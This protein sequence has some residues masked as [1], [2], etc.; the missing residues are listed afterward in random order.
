MSQLLSLGEPDEVKEVCREAIKIAYPGYFI[1]STTELDNSAKL[2]N[3][4]A[5]YEVTREKIK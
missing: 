2:E 4:I 5:M 1:G 3:I